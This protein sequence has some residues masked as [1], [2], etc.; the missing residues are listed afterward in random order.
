[1]AAVDARELAAIFAG[2]AIGTTVRGALATWMPSSSTHWPTV[3]FVVNVVGAFL[4]GYVATR[5]QERLPLSSYRR[6]LLGTGLCGGLTTFSTMQLEIVRMLDS[7][8]Y[9][10]AAAYTVASIVAGLLA[11]HT[12]TALVRRVRLRG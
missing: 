3:T 4:L 2:G 10:L 12:A 6:P 7:G 5:L 11:V 8:A 9:V 1:M